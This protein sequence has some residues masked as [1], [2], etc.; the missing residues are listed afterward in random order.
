MK[1]LIACERSGA[2]RRA[3]RA[4]GHDAWSCDLEPADDGDIHHIQDDAIKVAYTRRWDA[5]IAHPVCTFLCNSGSKHLYL[6]GRKENGPEPDRWANMGAGAM[7][8][9]TLWRAPIRRKCLENPIMLGHPRRLFGIPKPTQIVQPW[10]FG[11]PET[12]GTGLWIDGFMPLRPLYTTWEECREAL[13]LPPD[14]KPE[15]RIFRMS[16]GPQR[17]RMRSETFDCIAQAKADQWGG[18]AERLAA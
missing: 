9:L 13:G 16:P 14:A 17:G 2:I 7:F 1:W 3:L 15:Q 10:M 8:F 11:T 18:L 4:R 5:M 12:K 6:G